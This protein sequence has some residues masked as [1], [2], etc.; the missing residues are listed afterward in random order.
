MQCTLHWLTNWSG[1]CVEAIDKT[2]WKKMCVR[3][4]I[5]WN[6]WLLLQTK[7]LYGLCD[8]CGACDWIRKLLYDNMWRLTQWLKSHH[9][10]LFWIGQPI[11]EPA[12]AKHTLKLGYR[13]GTTSS[14]KIILWNDLSIPH[15]W[16]APSLDVFSFCAG[17]AVTAF[18]FELHK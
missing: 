17:E 14:R 1:P 7:K 5:L 18:S 12:I 13:W 4:L 6:V 10:S 3:C 8:L 16:V 11:W 9:Q 2:P 15:N